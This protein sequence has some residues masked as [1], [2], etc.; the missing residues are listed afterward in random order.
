MTNKR[1]KLMQLSLVDEVPE[2]N[3]IFFLDVFAESYF[4]TSKKRMRLSTING[5]NIPCDLKVSCPS[6]LVSNYPEGTIF[7]LDARLV[8]KGEDRKPYF[9]AVNRNNLQRALE[10][11]DYNL[12][13]Q[14]GF[15][16]VFPK[17]KDKKAK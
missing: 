13:I 3:K 8:R 17:K 10:F 16:Y 5:Q 11:F 15:D 9:V 4:D 6:K 14:N 1:L 7:K 12:K 2:L